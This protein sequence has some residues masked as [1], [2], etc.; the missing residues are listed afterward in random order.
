MQQ[1]AELVENRLDLA[2]GEQRRQSVH[3]RRQVSADEP[4]VRLQAVAERDAGKKAS[5]QAPPRLFSRGNQSA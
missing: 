4:D 5:I 1:M 3:R 2:M